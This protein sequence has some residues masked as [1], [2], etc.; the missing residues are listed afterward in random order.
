M[1]KHYIFAFLA[2]LLLPWSVRAQNVD[3]LTETYELSSGVDSAMWMEMPSTAVQLI[4]PGAGDYG[5]TSTAR[6]IGF[7]FTLAGTPYTQFSANTDGTVRFGSTLV[8]TG[9]YDNPFNTSLSYNQP[10]ICGMGC[11]GWMA[12]NGYCKSWIEGSEGSRV[13]VIEILTSTYNNSSRAGVIAF[14]VQLYEGSNE[15]LI[16]Y[17]PRPSVMPNVST[18]IGISSSTT[19]I[20]LFSYDGTMTTHTGATTSNNSSGS[21]FEAWRWFSLN[22]DPSVC[23]PAE[24][25]AATNVGYNSATLSWLESDSAASYVLDIPEAGIVEESVSGG[26]YD[27]SDLTS[28]TT[29]HASLR[30]VCNSGDTSRVT[31]VTFT[32]DTLCYPVTNISVQ[33]TFTTAAVTWDYQDGRGMDYSDVTLTLTD[34]S[35]DTFVQTVTTSGNEAFFSGLAAAHG[36]RLSIQTA[37]SDEL[38]AAITRTFSTSSG[39]GGGRPDPGSG[40]TMNTSPLNT[41]S[42]YSYSQAIFPASEV[43]SPSSVSGVTFYNQNGSGE[44]DVDLYMANTSLTQLS[45]TS[46]VPFS[47]FVQVGSNVHLVQGNGST[48]V[49]FDSAFVSDGRNLAFIIVGHMTS[50]NAALWLGINETNRVLNV[51]GTSPINPASPGSFSVGF[52]SYCYS[53]VV[54]VDLEGCLPPNVISRATGSDAAHVAWVPGN[55]ETNFKVEYQTSGDS[56]WTEAV[57]STTSTSIDLTDLDANTVYS[58]RV[59]ALCSDGDASATTTFRTDCGPIALPYTEGFENLANNTWASCWYRVQ[60]YSSSYPNVYT[61]SG[62]HQGQGYMYTYS[63]SSAP[64]FIASPRIP[65]APD[66]IYVSFWARG[67]LPGSGL[68]VGVMTNPSVPSSFVP[69]TVLPTGEVQGSWTEYEFTTANINVTDSVHVA[70]RWQASSTYGYLDDVFVSE[71]PACMPVDAVT[72]S[73]VS[74]NEATIHIVDSYATGSYLVR[75]VRNNEL[76]DSVA[77]SDTAVTFSNLSSVS[78]YT[79]QVFSVCDD[80]SITRGRST[81]FNTPCAVLTRSDLPLMDNF[82][83]YTGDAINPC[84][85]KF[86]FYTS[87]SY[88]YPV[89]NTNANHTPGGSKSLYF[90]NG[91]NGQYNYAVLPPVDSLN[92]LMLTFWLY[93]NNPSNLQMQVGTM[94]TSTDYD[95]FTPIFTSPTNMA[96][97]TWTEFDVLVPAGTTHQYL[98]FR[99]QGSSYTSGFVDDVVLMV[100]PACMHPASVSVSNISE[101]EATVSINDPSETGNYVILVSS[102]GTQVDSIATSDTSYTLTNL[103]ASSS[104]TVSVYSICSDNSVTTAVSANFRTLCGAITTLPWTMDFEGLATGSNNTFSDPCWTLLNRYSTYPYPYSS[105]VHSGSNCLYI[106]ST[107]SNPLVMGLPLF[108]DSLSQLELSFWM[109]STSTS[110]GLQ[111][112]YL[113]NPTDASSFVNVATYNTASSETNTYVERVTYF[114]AGATGVMAIRYGGSS[115]GTI[116]LDDITVAPIP[117]CTSPS[118]LTVSNVD[119]TAA[120]V[121]I[122]DPGNTDHYMLVVNGTD[123]IEVHGNSYSLTNLSPNT[124]YALQAFTL[125]DDGTMT[126]RFVSTTFRTNC[127]TITELPWL[128]DFEDYDGLYGSYAN[129]MVGD[130]PP[131]Y[132]FIAQSNSGFMHFTSSNYLYQGHSIAFYP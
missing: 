98:A 121:A 65:T 50:S 32:T 8:T 128:E 89:A 24:H 42:T 107:L 76:V 11:D 43:G 123:S 125:C 95:N 36:Y 40:G 86:N 124:S 82:D 81:L 61:G 37:C 118:S 23:R 102:N 111:V 105:S 62:A 75:L 119:M 25:F 112:G 79:V 35:D 122:S 33:T 132:D 3:A 53:L 92:G 129:R 90:Y 101:D 56:Q 126:T 87:G 7:T 54:S 26:S 28:S 109:R 130:Y 74:E 19:D 48:T 38:S 108:S 127:G 131:C 22:P 80:G 106:Y 15:V 69:C 59:T 41:G 63:T 77:T 47:D 78:E 64:N 45:P 14:Q 85:S 18:Q 44:W 1:R 13:R 29:Y 70:F 110:Y 67:V 91:P 104:Y 49:T 31:S 9:N 10:K 51:T 27:L 96:A 93:I 34:P 94:P 66:N 88:N 17:G 84:W 12:S 117:S 60:D 58:V 73:D 16:V 115:S 2:A 100:A 57:A 30:V 116:Y 4:A 72:V 6:D 68:T 55:G 114:P 39:D 120:D 20:V 97:T 5:T 71:I 103:S 46:Y 52:F 83:N 99:N 21:W 113:T